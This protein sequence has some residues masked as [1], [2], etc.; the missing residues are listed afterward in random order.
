MECVK[1]GEEEI[2]EAFCQSC[3][4]DE[5]AEGV[6]EG[7]E[8]GEEEGRE[9]GEEA[10]RIAWERR[11]EDEARRANIPIPHTQT[12]EQQL[13]AMSD[14]ILHLERVVGEDA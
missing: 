7:R 1:C 4:D 14:R 13:T 8:E 12:A 6:V 10:E 9:A 5:R 11:I 3:L 2:P